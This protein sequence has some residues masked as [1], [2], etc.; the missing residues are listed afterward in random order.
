MSGVFDV[1][2]EQDGFA[3]GILDQALGLLG[4]LR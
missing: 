1:A 4:V 3:A 2:R